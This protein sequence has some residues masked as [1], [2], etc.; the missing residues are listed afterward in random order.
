MRKTAENADNMIAVKRLILI[1]IV[2]SLCLN[3]YGEIDESIKAD[4]TVKK[5]KE[6]KEGKFTP[7]EFMLEHIIDKHEWHIVTIGHTPITIPLPIILY[8]NIS[9]WHFFFSTKFHLGYETY[10][11]FKFA[12]EGKNKDKIVEITSDGEI[13]PLDMSVT[14]VVFSLFLSTIIII[15]LFISIAK[16]YLRNPYK[17]PSGIQ[18]AMEPMILFVRDDI[19]KPSIG[20]K[21]YEK[22]MPYLLTIFFFILL[23][24]F[25]GMIPIFPGGA[26]I[27]G[28]IA[29]TMVMAIFTFV[30]TTFNAN[31]HYWQEIYNAPGVPWWLKFPIPLIPL[32]ELMG[33]II[34]PV[35]LMVRLFANITAGHLIAIA[36]V[37]LIFIFAE[38]HPVLGYGISVLS[39]LFSIFMGLLEILVALIQAYVF[40]LLSAIYFG[41]ATAEHHETKQNH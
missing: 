34:K 7:G 38:I 6:D 28:N 32:I 27:N 5:T 13:V 30:I 2:F 15:I 21:K 40:T 33:V 12:K 29:V 26:N 10:E 41:M 35:V 17:A 22:F 8:S 4:S 24:N 39:A 9:G 25:L 1:T 31:K 14:K 3:F 11:N 37:S 23:N 20:E 18:S 19:A 16:Q 36:F